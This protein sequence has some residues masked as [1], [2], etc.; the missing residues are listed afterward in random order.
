MGKNMDEIVERSKLPPEELGNVF[1]FI[2][3]E[4]D[5]I[6]FEEFNRYAE[7]AGKIAPHAKDLQYFALAL[8]FN[9]A[10]WSDEKAFKSKVKVFS[11]SE[12]ISFLSKT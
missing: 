5:F 10:I 2:K 1:R 7:E 11:T 4:I 9:A 3:R 6:P 12:L 8:S